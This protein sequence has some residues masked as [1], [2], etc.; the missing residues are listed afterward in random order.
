MLNAVSVLDVVGGVMLWM[1]LRSGGVLGFVMSPI[2]FALGI[3][4]AVPFMLVVTVL[5]IVLL[6]VGWSSL[7]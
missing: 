3:E 1:V 5:R 2:V 4:F 6:V 7:R